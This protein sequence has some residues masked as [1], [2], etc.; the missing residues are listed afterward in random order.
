MVRNVPIRAHIF[1]IP[2]YKSP[3]KIEDIVNLAKDLDWIARECSRFHFAQWIL[4]GDFNLHHARWSLPTQNESTA[5]MI[6]ECNLLFEV[7]AK[8]NLVLLNKPH[9]IT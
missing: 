5:A 8:H 1:A 2:S 7:E 3:Q 4:C 6:N 9:I